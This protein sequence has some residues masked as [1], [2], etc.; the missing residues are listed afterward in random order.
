LANLSQKTGKLVKYTQEKYKNF[1]NFWSKKIQNLLEN[2]GSIPVRTSF[3]C[4][5]AKKPLK[6]NNKKH[7][8]VGSNILGQG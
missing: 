3:D 5:H 4:S 1:P 6:S 8:F 7:M 2:L